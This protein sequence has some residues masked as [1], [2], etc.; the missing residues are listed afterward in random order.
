MPDDTTPDTPWTL[1]QDS[2]QPFDAVASPDGAQVLAVSIQDDEDT[3]SQRAILWRW[4]DL[5]APPTRREIASID[6]TQ[7]WLHA[8]LANTIPQ[9]TV[10]R[11]EGEDNALTVEALDATSGERRAAWQGLGEI[12]LRA[13]VVFSP[14]DRAI[15]LV[16]TP[17]TTRAR[18]I[19]VLDRLTGDEIARSESVQKELL[20]QS[21][22]AQGVI[23][24]DIES[25][26]VEQAFWRYDHAAAPALTSLDGLPEEDEPQWSD[27]HNDRFAERVL[28]TP[29]LEIAL[30]DEDGSLW[31]RR[32]KEGK[33][34]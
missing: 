15:A 11:G 13:G 19:V 2:D 3:R 33:A 22:G 6:A 31:W 26:S 34:L 1:L 18:Q 8:A 4:A 10:V 7:G 32:P 16:T 9:V 30:S 24:E 29:T 17:D 20:L 27:E 12:D 23:V 14:D 21:W 25:A 28:S 5:D